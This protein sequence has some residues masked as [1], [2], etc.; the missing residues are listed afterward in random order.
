MFLFRASRLEPQ[1]R[2]TNY[3]LTDPAGR[4]ARKVVGSYPIQ[5]LLVYRIP[6]AP[7]GDLFPP[8]CVVRNN[9]PP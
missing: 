8:L 9:E 2:K 6:L 3:L 7:E 1:E 4:E 5:D